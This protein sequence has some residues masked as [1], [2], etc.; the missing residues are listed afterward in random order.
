MEGSNNWTC[1]PM[2]AHDWRILETAAQTD[3][4]FSHQHY[5]VHVDVSIILA[6][7]L[8]ASSQL[9]QPLQH[10]PFPSLSSASLAHTQMSLQA[11]AGLAPVKHA[12]HA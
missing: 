9:L 2:T 3:E 1:G 7:D 10:F 5:L 11:G 4:A 12:K 8:S 6:A